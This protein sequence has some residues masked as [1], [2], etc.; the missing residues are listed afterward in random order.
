MATPATDDLVRRALEDYRSGRS[1]RARLSA[2]LT[3]LAWPPLP[4][5]AGEHDD[6]LPPHPWDLVSAALTDHIVDDALYDEIAD[7]IEAQAATPDARAH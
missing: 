6:Y 1:D 7:G 3:S 4:R 2:Q 5:T